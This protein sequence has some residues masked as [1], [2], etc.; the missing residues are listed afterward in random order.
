MFY[1][2]LDAEAPDP[3]RLFQLMVDHAEFNV[4][5]PGLAQMYALL[6]AEACNEEHPAH[7]YFRDRYDRVVGFIE[8][9]LRHGV[10]N[11]A[12]RQGIDCNAVAREILAVSDGFQLQWG[13]SGGRWDMPGAVRGYLDRLARTLTTDG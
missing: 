2:T 5:Q 1:G 11:G 12:L 10:A 7:A 6:A 8:R 4:T 13:L 3:L 9:C